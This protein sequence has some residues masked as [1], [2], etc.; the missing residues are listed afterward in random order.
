MMRN[1]KNESKNESGAKETGSA[2]RKDFD[3]KVKQ[4]SFIATVGAGDEG[5]NTGGGMRSQRRKGHKAKVLGKGWHR[6]KE[7]D[8]KTK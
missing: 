6:E 5:D 8:G 7:S 3:G 1:S 2:T 4:T